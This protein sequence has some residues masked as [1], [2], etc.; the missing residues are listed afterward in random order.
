VNTGLRYIRRR[1][2][3]RGDRLVGVFHP[4]FRIAIGQGAQ[5]CTRFVLKYYSVGAVTVNTRAGIATRTVIATSRTRPTVKWF[6]STPIFA[7]VFTAY[8]RFVNARRPVVAVFVTFTR[9]AK[10]PAALELFAIPG[11]PV[12]RPQRIRQRI[13]KR[14]RR[15]V[16]R[17]VRRGAA[18]KPVRVFKLH[19]VVDGLAS[20]T[21]PASSGFAFSRQSLG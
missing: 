1:G 20:C 21:N 14:I 10:W 11:S 9:V 12:N 18:L 8:C 16:R 17:G 13:C 5:S 4:R 19:P 15:V 3:R 6:S 7:C 2:V